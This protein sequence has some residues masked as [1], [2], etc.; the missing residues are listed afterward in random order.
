MFLQEL[1]EVS[2]GSYAVVKHQFC[3]EYDVEEISRSGH[4]NFT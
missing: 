1:H 4:A 2:Q 3:V